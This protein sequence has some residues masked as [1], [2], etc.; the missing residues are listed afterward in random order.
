MEVR[1]KAPR[2]RALALSLAV[3]L[4]TILASPERLAACGA[5]A[6]CGDVAASLSGGAIDQDGLRFSWSTNDE[7]G[8]VDHYVLI[9]YNC[10]NSTSCYTTVATVYAGQ[11]CNVDTPYQVDDYPPT[12]LDQWLYVL[13]VWRTHGRA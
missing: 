13:E 1:M 4:A 5:S 3:V 2:T 9:R 8:T 12:P 10:T 6:V 11:S 7:D